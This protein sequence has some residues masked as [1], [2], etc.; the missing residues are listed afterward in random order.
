MLAFEFDRDRIRQQFNASQI[1]LVS[2]ALCGMLWGVFRLHHLFWVC[3]LIAVLFLVTVFSSS[4]YLR[5][6]DLLARCCKRS[7][8]ALIVN[9]DGIIV[10]ALSQT[11]GQIAWQDIEKMYP[12]ELTERLFQSNWQKMPV[13]SKQRGL[14]IILKTGTDFQQRYR[15]SGRW[16]VQWLFIPEMMLT[17]T[18]DGVIG[19][20]NEFYIAQVRGAH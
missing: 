20:L 17:T 2:F 7:G 11:S 6:H 18:A 19:R 15:D 12:M 4:A 16:K 3:D 8:P 5:R 9:P 1:I 13:V 14:A 10:N